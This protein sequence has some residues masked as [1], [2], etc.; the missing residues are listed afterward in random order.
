MAFVV[1]CGNCGHTVLGNTVCLVT[2]I[3]IANF[4]PDLHEM[5]SERVIIK[6]KPF[7]LLY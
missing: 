4:K 5:F 1:N 3:T 2:M 7:I 6:S